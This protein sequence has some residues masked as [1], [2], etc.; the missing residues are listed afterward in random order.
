MQAREIFSHEFC[1]LP[2]VLT[3]R[4]IYTVIDRFLALYVDFF[5]FLLAFY[6]RI[7]S[8]LFRITKA[9]TLLH[10]FRQALVQSQAT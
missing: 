2:Q 4:H 10:A 8:T 1:S 6:Q 5:G 3:E 7:L 9:S